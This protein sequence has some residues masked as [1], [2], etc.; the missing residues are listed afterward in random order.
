V[1]SLPSAGAHAAAAAGS[2]APPPLPVFSFALDDLA[3][4]RDPRNETPVSWKF[5]LVSGTQPVRTVDVVSASAGGYSFAAISAAEAVAINRAIETAEQDKTVAGG[6]Y[7]LRL[8]RVPALYVTAL[9]LKNRE[10]G[11][12]R[13]V[14]VPPAPDGFRPYFVED[15][16][17]FLT[18]LRIAAKQRTGARPP[19]TQS[20]TN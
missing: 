6:D 8:A 7:E 17:G 11:A 9:W 3:A 20:P 15:V 18:P 19:A 10:G 14:V 1:S 4:G 16:D 13:F 5:L 12:D 2:K